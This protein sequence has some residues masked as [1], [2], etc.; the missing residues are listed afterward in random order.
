VKWRVRVLK[1]AQNDLLAIQEYISRD[2][3]TA[4]NSWL[5]GVLALLG[6]L[7]NFA[8]RGAVAKD[9]RLKRLGYRYML[10]GEYIVFYKVSASQVRVYR[11]L[12][13]RRLYKHLL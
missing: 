6:K 7:E 3:P 1:R 11:V 4:A 9:P 13:G 10:H 8:N 12:H 5:R 2:D